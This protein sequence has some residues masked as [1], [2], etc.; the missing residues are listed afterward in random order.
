MWVQVLQATEKSAHSPVLKFLR[1]KKSF[2][3]LVLESVSSLVADS[4]PYK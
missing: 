2:Y 3:D 4:T 1:L